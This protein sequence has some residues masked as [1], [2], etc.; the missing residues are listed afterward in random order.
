[1][2]TGK[3]PW[4]QQGVPLSK[5]LESA[6]LEGASLIAKGP[7]DDY[8]LTSITVAE[9]PYGWKLFRGGE[10]VLTCGYST[11]GLSKERV[12]EFL[13]NLFA[14][15][16]RALAVKNEWWDEGMYEVLENEA[17]AAGF[18]LVLLP[19]EIPWTTVVE[20]FHK[21]LANTTAEYRSVED[22]CDQLISKDG[23]GKALEVLA[24]RVENPVLLETPELE[25]IHRTIPVDLQ[26]DQDAL[27]VRTDPSY[28]KNAKKYVASTLRRESAAWVTLPPTDDFPFAQRFFPIYQ[29]NEVLAY[30]SII[31][32]NNISKN[33]VSFLQLVTK[34]LGVHLA[35][36]RSGFFG[37]ID[38]RRELLEKLL[39][40]GHDLDA[41]TI[42]RARILGMNIGSPAIVGLVKEAACN[43][44][45]DEN[46]S[47]QKAFVGQV[48]SASKHHGI[49]CTPVT[50]ESG[51]VVL[52]FFQGAETVKGPFTEKA[53][54]LL[55]YV[56]ES[57][58][59]TE[60]EIVLRGTLGRIHH[61]TDAILESFK[62]AEIAMNIA[63]NSCV[64]GNVLRFE[65]IGIYRYF[66]LLKDAPGFNRL[67]DEDLSAFDD[68]PEPRRSDFLNTLLSY[69]ENQGSIRKMASQLHV[70]PNTVKQRLR[71]ISE[72]VDIENSSPQQSLGL[73]LA[74]YFKTAYD[75]KN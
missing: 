2:E 50:R 1:M 10:L 16:A 5:L 18:P 44:G 48:A 55:K 62:E 28:L 42:A 22:I 49:P 20:T 73:W 65:D 30:L 53:C 23:F 27:K 59:R 19:Q 66:A 11:R 6:S 15:G 26:M 58:K 72:Y 14:H 60:P 38:Y 51:D 41:D 7:C 71:K 36:Q 74:L 35:L 17:K 32:I 52:L 12:V 43:A 63:L 46:G 33:A 4:V 57:V 31:E 70:H 75:K 40:R 13:H 24:A 56:M 25:P 68:I 39:V 9:T 69:F 64:A 47:W 8:M 54:N 61:G 21:L 3:M 34:V 45:H 29:S 67:V 37:D